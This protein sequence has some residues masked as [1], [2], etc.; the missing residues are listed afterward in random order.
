MNSRETSAPDVAQIGNLL[1]R[2]LAVGSG[3]AFWTLCGLPIR[4][5]A[6]C[7][8]ALLWMLPDV[9]LHASW[10]FMPNL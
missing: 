3:L 7:Q 4:D 5:T 9:H 1:F 2:R 6:D 10:L 8:S